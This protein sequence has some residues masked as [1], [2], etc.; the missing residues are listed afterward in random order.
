[1][2]EGL[3]F[4]NLND[5]QLVERWNANMKRITWAARF[6]SPQLMESLLRIRMAI[7]AEQRERRLLAIMKNI[8]DGPVVITDPEMAKNN[9]YRKQEPEKKKTSR[10]RLPSNVMREVMKPSKTP[11]GE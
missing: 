8:P 7:E 4:T 11:K 2:F 5:T 1:M 9:P 3:D 10:N 6:G